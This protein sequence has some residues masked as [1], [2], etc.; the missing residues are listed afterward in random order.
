M[1]AATAIIHGLMVV[2]RNVTDF[3]RLDVALL[4]PWTTD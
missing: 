2:T 1:I 4:N 3:E